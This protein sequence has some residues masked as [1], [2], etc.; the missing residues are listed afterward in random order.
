MRQSFFFLSVILITFSACKTDPKNTGEKIPVS[1]QEEQ[2]KNVTQQLA[3]ATL[4]FQKSAERRALSYQ[5][6]NWAKTRLVSHL[7]NKKDTL[8]PCVVLDIDE[9]VLDN[10]P[11]EGKCIE[12]GK[13]YSPEMWKEWSDMAQAGAIPGALDFCNFSKE[14]GV[15]LFYITN[16]RL[17]EL[18]ASIKNL[19]AL[20]FPYSDPDHILMRTEESSKKA[21]RSKIEESHSILLLIGDNLDDFNELFEDR[22]LDLGFGT[23][24]RER[25]QFGN[26]FIMLPNPMYGSWESAVLKNETDNDLSKAQKRIRQ[27]Q[28]Y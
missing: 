28:S 17:D 7:E 13:S 2:D 10:S 16:R 18:E 1:G 3:G 5:A 26:R 8:P 20:G 19:A 21:R 25:K 12:T 9:T 4:W 14:R 27:I 23:V 24:D 22:Q 11:F 6:Y 15:E